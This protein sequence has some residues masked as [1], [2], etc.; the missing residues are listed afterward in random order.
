MFF[1]VAFLVPELAM[2][3]AFDED[4][5]LRR[6]VYVVYVASGLTVTEW[7]RVD[8]C[9]GGTVIH[10]PDPVLY[11]TIAFARYVVF[12]FAVIEVVWRSNVTFTIEI[13]QATMGAEPRTLSDFGSGGT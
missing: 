11:F 5:E 10:D 6:N 1:V 8:S 4:V 2:S 9:T 13:P 7:V 12:H 3:D